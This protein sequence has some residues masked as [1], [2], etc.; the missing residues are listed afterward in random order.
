MPAVTPIPIADNM[1]ASRTTD[2][3]DSEKLMASG[4][5]AALFSTVDDW[6]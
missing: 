2:D 6:L 5:H 1:M 4:T 3:F